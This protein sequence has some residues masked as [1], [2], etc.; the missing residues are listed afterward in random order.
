MVVAIKDNIA[1]DFEP[2]YHAAVTVRLLDT[3]ADV[4]GTT[5]MDL[6]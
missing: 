5:N 1:I 4:V 3:G 2:N 6:V